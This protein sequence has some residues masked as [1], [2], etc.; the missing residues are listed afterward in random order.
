MW[1]RALAGTT[2]DARARIGP[3]NLQSANPESGILPPVWHRP[4]VLL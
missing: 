4:H 1:A 2:E 3:R